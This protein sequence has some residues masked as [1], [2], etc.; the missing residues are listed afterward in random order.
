M[1]TAQSIFMKKP[2]IVWYIFFGIAAIVAVLCIPT[3]Y[4]HHVK[5]ILLRSESGKLLEII[6]Y[7]TVDISD[8]AL[9]NKCK[10]FKTNLWIIGICLKAIPCF[11]LLWFTLALMMRLHRNN[12]RRA[13]LLYSKSNKGARKR[14]Q[15]YDRTTFTLIV[16]LTVFLTTEM[17][18]GA[19]T[20]L[21]GFYTNDVHMVIYMNLANVLDLLSLI[22][23]YVGFIAYCFLCSKYRQTFMIMIVQT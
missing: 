11:L 22:N 12:T 14:K 8:F 4:V 20:C 1:R 7:Y 10:L 18:Q 19:I 16:V 9:Q 5:P 2:K 3:Y 17:P 6:D 23:C 13:M 21:N 15:N